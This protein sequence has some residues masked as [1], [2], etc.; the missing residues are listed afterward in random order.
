M[1][2]IKKYFSS[3]KRV[4]A[5][6]ALAAAMTVG[7]GFTT[8]ADAQT[9]RIQ[10]RDYIVVQGNQRG[11]L[12]QIAATNG[13]YEGFERGQRD[14]QQRRGFNYRDDAIYRQAT[15]G[16]QGRWGRNNDYRTYFRQG[17]V[18]G[19]S[20]G[21]YSRQRNRNYD[22]ARV[23]N[24]QVYDYRNSP[25]DPYY[26]YPSYGNYSGGGVP[27]YN[28]ERGDESPQEVAQRGAQN[29]Y[30]AGFQRGAYDAQQRNRANPQGHGAYQFGFDGFDPEWGSAA[31]YQS[32]YRNGFLQGYQD[33]YNRRTYNRRFNRRF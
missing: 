30:Y 5:A 29:G 24:N 6:V 9:Y 12:R 28:N 16:F 3:A 23:W 18:Q 14:R 31:V 22:R 11:D 19:Y 26:N 13:Y 27:Y 4:G 1:N 21:Y 7:A 20:D 2:S 25:Y 8:T 10:G 33:G 17:F 15:T 32:N